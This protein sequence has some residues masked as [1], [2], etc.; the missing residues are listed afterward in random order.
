MKLLKKKQKKK[1]G[2]IMTSSLSVEQISWLKRWSLRSNLLGKRRCHVTQDQT[3]NRLAFAWLSRARSAW[4]EQEDGDLAEIEVDK[5]LCLVRHI[6][7]EVTANDAMPGRVVLLV[8]FLLDEGGD[9][10]LNVELL[11]GLGGNVD[12]VLLHVLGHV[13][14]LN[15]CLSVCHSD[16]LLFLRAW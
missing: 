3:P 7:A 15:N 8:E 13:C 12:S 11:E 9:V 4:F 2:K 10:L 14:V 1:C 6:R 16:L 5:V